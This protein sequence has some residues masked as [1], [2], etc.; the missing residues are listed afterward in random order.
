[1]IQLESSNE[2]GLTRDD[3]IPDDRHAIIE[4]R[5][6]ARELAV[7]LA[8]VRPRQIEPR[9]NLRPRGLEFGS[10]RALVQLA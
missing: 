9:F 3:S 8:R 7:T 4:S 10:R 2:R 1:M 5:L 6:I